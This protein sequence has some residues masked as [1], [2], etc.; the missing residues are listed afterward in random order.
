MISWDL[1]K[2][3]LAISIQCPKSFEICRKV[4]SK[5]LWAKFCVQSDLRMV[6]N[7]RLVQGG[8]FCVQSDLKRSQI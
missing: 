5:W 6:A 3:K 4:T 7:G 1:E 8:L 2:V